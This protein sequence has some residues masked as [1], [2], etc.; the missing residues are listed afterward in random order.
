M[1]RFAVHGPGNP[2]ASPRS[3]RMPCGDVPG[4]VHVRVA[5]KIAGGALEDGLALTRL[6]VH[7]PACA[8]PLTR[9]RGVN[10]LDSAG[11]LVL[12]AANQ[13][14]PTRRED[15]SVQA[16]LLTHVT[17]RMI[18]SS[19]DTPGH[20]F[21]VQVFDPDDIE[22]ARQVS[23]DLLAPV[24]AG[25]NLP[26]PKLSKGEPD[27]GPAVAAAFR[28][29]QR[30]LQQSQ[31][32]LARPTQSGTAQQFTSGQ[33]CAN[34][35]S[36]VHT[37]GCPGTRSRDGLGHR[38]ECHVPSARAV[39]GDPERLHAVGDVPGPAESDPS[40]FRDKYH[41]CFPVQPTHMCGSDCNDTEPLMT[42]GLAPGR[43][44]V[45][46]G[47]I[48]LHGLLE[49]AE[50][51]L[52]HHLAA[53]CQPCEFPSRRSELPALF[54]VPRRAHPAVTPPRLLFAGEVPHES[55]MCAM[56]AEHCFLTSRRKQAITGHT[57]KLASITDT[58]EEIKS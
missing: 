8:A 23:A 9:E 46:S 14:A 43:P 21:D 35:Y 53:G 25:V 58:P 55:G 32:L 37:D 17:P 2:V 36:P 4:R 51:L 16:S 38:G 7:M 49:V 44:A 12:Q 19:F 26:H 33:R 5:G 24:L 6:P 34:G 50:R 20:I 48:V 54:Q 30:A 41:P 15:L 3:H 39:Q 52:L 40:T 47:E 10:L 45:S 11:S 18:D 22:P 56:L 1:L 31:A 57:K 29:G 13:Q 27:L 42:S 28:A